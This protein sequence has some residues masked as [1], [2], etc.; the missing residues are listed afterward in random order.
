MEKLFIFKN[1]NKTLYVEV[2]PR[3]VALSWRLDY[4]DGIED[5]FGLSYD[6]GDLGTERV[7]R[8]VSVQLSQTAEEHFLQKML[9]FGLFKD[10]SDYIKQ[11]M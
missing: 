4:E 1:N 11:F 8:A 9:D 6:S 3:S 7:K 10:L 2:R 5:A